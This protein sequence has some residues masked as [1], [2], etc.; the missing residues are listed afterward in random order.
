MEQS[1][2]TGAA[3]WDRIEI[4]PTPAWVDAEPY[5][6]SLR[7]KDGAHVTQLLWARQVDATAGRSFHATALRLETPLAVQHESQ[8]KLNLDGRR[9]RL[10]LHWLRLVRGETKIDQLKREHMRLMQRETQLEHHVIDG[11]WTLLV[12]LEDVRPGDVIEAGYSSEG[13]HPVRPEGCEVFFVVPPAMNV[14]RWRLSVLSETARAGLH[15]KTSDDAPAPREE[16]LEGGRRRW[17]WEGA[18]AAPREPEPNLPSS[19]LDYTWVQVSDLTDWAELAGRVDQVWAE[20]NRGD[21]ALDAQAFAKPETVDAAA[22]LGLVRQ[23]QDGFRYL[24]MDLETG[25]WIPSP[26]AAVARRRHGDC[27]DLAWLAATVLRGWG[28]GARPVLV[29]TGLRERVSAL[30]PAAI[31]FNHAILEVEWAGEARWFDLTCRDLGG[32]FSKQAVGWF[33]QGLVIDG[34][35]GG[36]R[37][38]PGKRSGG[39]YELKETVLLDTGRS[40]VSLVEIR[41]RTEEW[42]ADNLR[43]AWLARGAE[44]F[45][46]EREEQAQRR[47][48]RARRLGELRWRDDRARNVWELVETFEIGEVVD[49]GEGGERALFDVPVNLVVQ[50]FLLPED[51]PRRGPWD[52]PYPM[53]VAHEIVVKSPSLGLGSGP[54]RR[55]SEPE[56]EATLEGS[57]VKGMW[58][59]RVRFR[60]GMAEIPAERV[61]GYRR[62]L[63]GLFRDLSW[64]LYLPWGQPR[65]RRGEGFGELGEVSVELVQGARLESAQ[66]TLPATPTTA[67][68]A[69]PTTAPAVAPVVAPAV[70]PA[71]APGGA[72]AGTTK[73]PRVAAAGG[74]EDAKIESGAR[75]SRRHSRSSGSSRGDSRKGRSRGLGSRA[76]WITLGILAFAAVL[77]LRAYLHF[78]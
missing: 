9:S 69:T 62:R 71:V 2:Y 54:R 73:T 12:V 32:D 6:A 28:V 51:K 36:L 33:G 16:S 77:A 39:K 22:I 17:A 40:G 59:N 13:V 49:L 4:A 72:E 50:S 3:P 61:A 43:R 19:Y 31:L 25:G 1:G 41:L 57:R 44:E 34:A 63:G 30:L 27:K 74:G 20:Q 75:S 24:S 48:G 64:R 23:V 7:A 14:G 15:W 66:R 78:Q 21:G 68:T 60:V 65:G 42:H 10:T 26:P 8:W 38:Q 47:Y 5:D 37:V 18:Q 35:R 11:S 56:F 76:F 46:R 53:E 70:A 52:M 58:T 67:P 55:W 29:A 45:A